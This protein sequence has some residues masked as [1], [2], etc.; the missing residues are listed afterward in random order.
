MKKSILIRVIIGLVIIGAALIYKYYI[1]EPEKV[2]NINT[3]QNQNQ[4]I[5]QNIK[6]VIEA[7]KIKDL[8]IQ[9][10]DVIISPVTITGQ[11]PGSWFFEGSFPIEVVDSVEG[12]IK[13]GYATAVGE[14]MTEDYVQFEAVIEFN[15]LMASDEQVGKIIFKKDN[16]SDLR[17]LDD[18]FELS[19]KFSE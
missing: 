16:P 5:N 1:A 17:E 12:I 3:N 2:N 8:N 18:S 4:N 15:N 14:W 6:A 13:Q 19:V 9:S 10:G 7:V 11:A